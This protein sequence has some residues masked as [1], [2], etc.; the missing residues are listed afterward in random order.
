[1]SAHL[2]KETFQGLWGYDSPTWAGKF[3]DQ[4]TRQVMRSRIKPMKKFARTIRAHR[5]LLLN[6][7]RA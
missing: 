5:E 6:Y 7:F 4:W 3:L 2:L 1:M